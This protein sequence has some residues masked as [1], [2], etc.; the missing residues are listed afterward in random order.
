MGCQVFKG[1][2]TQ[3]KF[4]YIYRIIVPS[5][6]KLGNISENKRFIQ[7]FGYVFS[8]QKTQNIKDQ[9][10]TKMPQPPLQMAIY[11]PETHYVVPQP[12]YKP[13]PNKLASY[14]SSK[15]F[16]DRGGETI[17]HY[18][19]KG[20]H[21]SPNCPERDRNGKNYSRNGDEENRTQEDSLGW[22]GNQQQRWTTSS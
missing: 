20:G 8:L 1:R 16:R 9:K 4:L 5:C 3:R 13:R 18:C 10:V 21:R 17:C 7:L 19:N 15:E 2:C 22:R 14:T 11:T 6:Q 12:T